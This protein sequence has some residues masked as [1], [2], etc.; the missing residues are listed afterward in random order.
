MIAIAELFSNTENQNRFVFI[1]TDKIRFEGNKYLAEVSVDECVRLVGIGY[2]V[3]TDAPQDIQ[4]LKKNQYDL[5]IP[6]LAD[7]ESWSGE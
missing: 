6:V 5:K 2:E 1:S 7:G 3:Y 4:L